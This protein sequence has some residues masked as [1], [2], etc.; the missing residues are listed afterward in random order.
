MLDDLRKFARFV[1]KKDAIHIFSDDAIIFG[2]LNDISKGGLSFKYTPIKEEKLV[3]NSINIS[4]KNHTKELK[5][6]LSSNDIVIA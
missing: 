3:T 5:C 6:N 4:A 2:K 1:F